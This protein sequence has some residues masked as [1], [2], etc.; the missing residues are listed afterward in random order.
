MVIS[1]RKTSV[2][3]QT[4]G[5]MPEITSRLEARKAAGIFRNRATIEGD[6]AMTPAALDALAD[7]LESMSRW[8]PDHVALAVAFLGIT[9]N[10]L[11][12]TL[13]GAP[14]PLA[15]WGSRRTAW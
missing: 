11:A 14:P 8:V 1:L 9:M 13:I 3:A 5:R 4:G 7:M 12:F 6:V 2:S 10:M 15:E